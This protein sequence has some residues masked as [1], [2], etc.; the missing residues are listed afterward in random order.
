MSGVS[1]SFNLKKRQQFLEDITYMLT[2]FSGS[3][4][5][6]HRPL[7]EII[8][9]FNK[10]EKSIDFIKRCEEM[11]LSGIDFPQA[12]AESIDNYCPLLKKNEKDKLTQYGRSI[13]KTDSKTQKSVL[14]EYCRYFDEFRNKA[15]YD[16][17][18]YNR[19]VIAA[20]FFLGCGLFI[21]FI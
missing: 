21:L 5:Y 11:L 20:F 16:Y 6:Y 12:W 8:A 1:I 17:N 19:T 10:N 3:I 13:G 7:S 4:N 15:T 14:D 18:K 2:S 9:D